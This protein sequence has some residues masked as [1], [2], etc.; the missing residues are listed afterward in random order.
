MPWWCVP[1]C[2]TGKHMGVLVG[3]AFE[4]IERSHADGFIVLDPAVVWADVQASVP[5]PFWR[6]GSAR[7]FAGE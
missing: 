1:L 7:P 6:R 5:A 4:C 3:A 2:L